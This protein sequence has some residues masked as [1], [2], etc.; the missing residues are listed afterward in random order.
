MG[1]TCRPCFPYTRKHRYAH[2]LLGAFPV[3][4]L[5]FSQYNWNSPHPK[6]LVPIVALQVRFP[7]NLLSE[8][9]AVLLE[10]RF[11]WTWVP[12]LL[13]TVLISPVLGSH[14]PQITSEQLQE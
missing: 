14:G 10:P 13:T 2:G 6:V 7:V 3:C 8:Q 11:H 9:D 12:G 1:E 5:T 4:V